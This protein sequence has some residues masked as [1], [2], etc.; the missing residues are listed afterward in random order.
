[1][2]AII[3]DPWLKYIDHLQRANSDDLAFYPLSTLAK[4][5]EEGRVIEYTENGAPAGYLWFGPIR[6]GHD[7]VIYQAVIDYDLRRRHHGFTMVGQLVELVR[8]GGGT[9]IRLK[10]ASSALSNLFWA[11]AGFYVTRVTPGGI[12]RGRDIN[13]FRT[14][15][16]TP[17]LVAPSV[18]PSTR[19]ID[20]RAY[21]RMKR[22]GI[23]MP[24]RFSRVHYGQQ[25]AVIDQLMPRCQQE[26]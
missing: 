19:P 25:Q 24:S 21:N 18:E 17:L 7:C 3:T 6:P 10:C 13:H 20:M 1:M 9:G 14:D 26:L 11:A 12:K 2:T 16:T 15:V 22:D 5:R 23:V 8:A 4:A